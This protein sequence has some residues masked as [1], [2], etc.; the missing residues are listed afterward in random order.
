ML[1]EPARLLRGLEVVLSVHEGLLLFLA[2]GDVDRADSHLILPV[3]VVVY[4]ES[5]G[6]AQ[7]TSTQCSTLEGEPCAYSCL[8]FFE[9]IRRRTVLRPRPEFSLRF[10]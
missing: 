6:A 1:R 7:G 5:K 3:N 2:H 10:A 9:T 8:V 4:M